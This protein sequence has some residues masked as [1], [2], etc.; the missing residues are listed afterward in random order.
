[1]LFPQGF[2]IGARPEN[3]CEPIEPPPRDNWTGAF[4]VLIKRFDCNFDMKVS[5]LKWPTQP[6]LILM[7]HTYTTITMWPPTPC[8]LLFSAFMSTGG[9]S[10]LILTGAQRSSCR[11]R[12]T[13]S[14]HFPKYNFLLHI[15]QPPFCLFLRF[16]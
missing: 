2:L 9:V 7:N 1:M 13:G 12:K 5:C 11:S 16:F 14:G 8:M 3:A 10:V 15:L 6:N 4:F